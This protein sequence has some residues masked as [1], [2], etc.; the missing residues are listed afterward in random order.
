MQGRMPYLNTTID[1]LEDLD[2]LVPDQVTPVSSPKTHPMHL[3]A[4]LAC[5]PIS[6]YFFFHRMNLYATVNPA[7]EGTTCNFCLAQTVSLSGKTDHKGVC[8]MF[9]T[10]KMYMLPT[11][12]PRGTVKQGVPKGSSLRQENTQILF[13][14]V[15]MSWAHCS[16]DS[17]VSPPTGRMLSL[18]SF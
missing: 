4:S 7:L 8:V 15:S 9:W 5:R 13:T 3:L 2:L 10:N 18:P 1:I 11:T 12:S 16:L 17:A 14:S 6:P